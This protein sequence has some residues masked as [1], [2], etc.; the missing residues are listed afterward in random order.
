MISSCNN[1]NDL[2][3]KELKKQNVFL[4]AQYERSIVF[5]KARVNSQPGGVLYYPLLR[6]HDTLVRT[7]L[8]DN[9]P[10][11]CKAYKI[12]IHKSNHLLDSAKGSNASRFLKDDEP[13]LVIKDDSICGQNIGTE[14]KKELLIQSTLRHAIVLTDLFRDCIGT[15]SDY[16]IL[17][18][19]MGYRLTIHTRT[20]EMILF[21]KYMEPRKIP[22]PSHLEFVSLVAV[23]KGN[24][25]SLDIDRDIKA[26]I[27]S[28]TYQ[29]DGILLKTQI[30]K[31]G[32]Y[33]IT[34]NLLSISENKLLEKQKTEFDF[35]ITENQ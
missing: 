27:I 6:A 18:S 35:E 28:Q 2:F 8:S 20:N 1:N 26:N 34:A 7:L 4:K 17:P 14:L 3:L 13:L 32:F 16:F 30:L 19:R 5:Y 31:K 12:Y 11:L 10:D 29:N 23:D 9:E 15:S 21:L 22:F 33:K 25:E 24:Y